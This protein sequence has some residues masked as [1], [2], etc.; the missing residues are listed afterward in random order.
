MNSYMPAALTPLMENGA[1]LNA[2]RRGA[3]SKQEN[4]LIQAQQMQQLQHLQQLQQFGNLA[5]RQGSADA[6][7]RAASEWG[8]AYREHGNFDEALKMFQ[9]AVALKPDL[10]ET[11]AQLAS[12]YKDTGRVVDAITHYRTT[13]QLKP[14][15]PDALCNLVHAYIFMSDWRD[16]ELNMKL[17]EQCL[18]MQLAQG[19]LPAIQPFHAFVYPIHLTKIKQLACAYAKR[20]EQIAHALVVQKKLVTEPSA[21]FTFPPYAHPAKDS[22][23]GV[24]PGGPR[25]RVG[26][27]S[28]DCVNH[29]LA[30]LMQSV[31][32]FH[33]KSRFEVFVYSLRPSDGSSHRH[34][35][36]HHT[37]HFREVPWHVSHARA[38]WRETT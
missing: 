1:A 10:A 23:L 24:T 27:V 36:E 37:E 21:G 6:L 22:S 3:K 31:F 33:D 29:P 32:N 17:L 28:S 11:H 25:L 30:H 7:A 12:T 5:E 16:Y 19:T 13:L 14:G 20:A 18:D 38:P 4:M 8:S 34:Q 35:I 2:E 15:S 26:Y 9:A